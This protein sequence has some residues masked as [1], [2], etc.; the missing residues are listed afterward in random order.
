[1][2]R[3]SS[4]KAP[5]LAV[6]ALS[7]ASFGLGACAKGSTDPVNFVNDD[8]GGGT[9]GINVLP[10]GTGGTVKIKS[11]S[12]IDLDSGAFK[13]LPPPWQYQAGGPLSYKDA[14]L[15]ADVKDQFTGAADPANKPVIVYPLDQSLHARNVSQLMFQWTQGSAANTLFKIEANDGSEK[16]DFYVPCNDPS[17]AGHCTYQMPQSEWLYIGALQLPMSFIVYGTDGK[18]GAVAASDPIKLTFSE[19]E[20]MGGL[21]YWASSIGTIKRA[22]FGASEAVEYISP[23]DGNLGLADTPCVACHSVS[24]DGSKI[25]FAVT[26]APDNQGHDAPWGIFVLPTS[27]LTKPLVSPPMN[28]GVVMGSFG[29]NVAL[30]RD[31]SLIAVNGVESGE[32]LFLDVRMTNDWRDRTFSAKTGNAIFKPYDMAL[33]PEWSPDGNNLAVTLTRVDWVG[34]Q[35]YWDHLTCNGT[36]GLLPWDGVQLNEAVPLVVNAK[37]HDGD[38]H[39]YP[40]W[41][42]DG[43]WIAF[44][45]QVGNNH[46]ADGG[47]PA[48]NWGK[49]SSYDAKNGILRMV[50]SSINNAPYTCPGPQCVELLNATQYGW[51]E[52]IARNGKGSNLPKFA[53]FTQGANNDIFF[54]TYTSR[55]DYGFTSSPDLR[56][57]WMSAIEAGK[58]PAG[59][60]ADGGSP[61]DPS[62]VPFWVPYQA[63][64]KNVEPYWTEILSCT[65]DPKG[66][67]QGCVG[68]EQCVTNAENECHCEVSIK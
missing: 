67:C 62:H 39:F 46:E 59:G 14:N 16:L 29:S 33:H 23:G 53:P 4:S 60:A 30:N 25:A 51:A 64:D 37:G 26:S 27:D 65:K 42:P 41:S 19:K 44:V 61:P 1:M 3:I 35:C 34:A 28:T 24:R 20:V 66:G 56:Q 57:L 63:S 54:L 47:G 15:P 52:A 45:S 11:D 6:A 10:T 8:G 31:G 43:K 38:A 12:S 58:V 48:D 49:Q 40:T 9:G 22:T 21:Y 18:G 36:I 2:S 32:T 55:M 17:G 68:G 7:L 13:A 5:L 50:P